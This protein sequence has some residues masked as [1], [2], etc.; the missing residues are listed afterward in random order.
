[1]RLSLRNANEP[2]RPCSSVVSGE[3]LS[4]EQR[5]E[6]V[7]SCGV[8]VLEADEDL[9]ARDRQH[10]QPPLAAGAE[11]RDSRP[12]PLGIIAESRIADA[13]P[14]HVVRVLV[15]GHNS[16]CQLS[17]EPRL[18]TTPRSAPTAPSTVCEAELLNRVS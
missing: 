16:E 11:T 10:Q 9:L 18:A 17:A 3:V 15:V 2:S 1:M 7:R 8:V 13:D 6:H 12:G 5:P 4:V 14:T